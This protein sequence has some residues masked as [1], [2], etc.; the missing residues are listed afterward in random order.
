MMNHTAAAVMRMPKKAFGVASRSDSG[1]FADFGG[2]EP[3]LCGLFSLMARSK[4]AGDT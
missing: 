2:R 3:P 4:A 1:A